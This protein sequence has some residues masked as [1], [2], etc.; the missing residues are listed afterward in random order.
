[1]RKVG[2]LGGTFDPIH[3]G[4]LYLV[5]QALSLAG[6][7][8]AVILPM[9][10]PAHRETDASAEDRLNMCRLALEGETRI[11]LSEAGMQ[12]SVR[13]T[14]DTLPYLSKEFPDACF[15]LI[16]GADKLPS[17]PYWRDADKLFARCEILCFPRS[18]VSTREAMEKVQAAGGRV[19]MLPTECPPWSSTLIRAAAARYEDAPGLPLS[20]QCY[21]AERGLYQPDHL[22]KLKGMMNPR[23]FKHTLGVR[24]E[25]VRLAAL[26]GLPVQKAALA[27]LLH[28]CAKGMPVPVMAQIAEQYHLIKDKQMLSSGAMMHGPVGAHVARHRFGV[29]DEDVLQ[30]IRHHTIGRPGMSELELCIFV[31]DA[32]EENREDYCGLEEI[33]RLSNES[34]AAAALKSLQLTH[35]FLKKTNRP[36]FPSAQRTAEELSARL[37]NDMDQ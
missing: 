21:M 35:E 4:H 8:E 17:L 22:P 30:A 9:A 29:R 28:D 20:V 19:R 33:R 25:A 13:Y 7:D 27:G 24:K 18:G 36:F 2:V 6:L 23:R 26:H 10:R 32:T 34:L 3:E 11:S 31:A 14:A 1:M 5:R 15:S 16:L 37:T 12:P